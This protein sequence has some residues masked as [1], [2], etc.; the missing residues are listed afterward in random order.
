MAPIPALDQG[1]AYS[2]GWGNYLQLGQEDTDPRYQPSLIEA[3]EEQFIVSAAC[4]G[5][6]T[7]LLSSKLLLSFSIYSH[8]LT[9]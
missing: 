5:W 6:H 1:K 7:L 8:L 4:G 2:F 3:I 9:S